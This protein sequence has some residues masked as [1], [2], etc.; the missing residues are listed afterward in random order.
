MVAWVD[1]TITAIVVLSGL[2]SL[3]RGFIKEALS[4]A[5]WAAAVFLA[6]HYAAPFSANF[7]HIAH[8]AEINYAVAFVIILVVCLLVGVLINATVSSL[9]K[10]T[11]VGA[12]DRVLGVLFG[13]LRGYLLVV[14]A[15]ML[16]SL[17]Q[18]PKSAV[19]QESGLIPQLMPSVD[20]LKKN[21]PDQVSQVST[22]FGDHT[23]K[24]SRTEK[25]GDS[26]Q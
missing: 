3:F 5:I 16:L 21:M 24:K 13:I 1:I 23:P 26:A 10:G 4:L 12:I 14:I 15:L 8:N 7:I 11:G 17:T 18:L 25:S 9:V 2:I 22:W 20:W 19:W 6:V